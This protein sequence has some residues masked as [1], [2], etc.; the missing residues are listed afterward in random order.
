M[1][2]KCSCGYEPKDYQDLMRHVILMNKRGSK[3]NHGAD[4]TE[5]G[6]ELCPECGEPTNTASAFDDSSEVM[7]CPKCGNSR[8]I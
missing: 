6:I 3:E 8:K 7:I 4:V 2:V 1:T 5:W